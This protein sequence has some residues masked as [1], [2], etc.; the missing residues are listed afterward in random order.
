MLKI[1]CLLFA[2]LMLTSCAVQTKGKNGTSGKD[3]KSATPILKTPE[4]NSA[5]SFKVEK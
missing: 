3:G 5:E 4:S 2:F 1:S